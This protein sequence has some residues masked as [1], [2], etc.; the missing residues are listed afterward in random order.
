[1]GS[2]PVLK[3]IPEQEQQLQLTIQDI[4]IPKPTDPKSHFRATLLTLPNP[5]MAGFI[6]VFTTKNWTAIKNFSLL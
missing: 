5:V 3:E 1:M 2:C 4:H 6:D